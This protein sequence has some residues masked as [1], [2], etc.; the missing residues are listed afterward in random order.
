M[1]AKLTMWGLVFCLV[2]GATLWAPTPAQAQMN[3][4]ELQNIQ[5]FLK[6][7]HSYLEISSQWYSLV[8]NREIAVY[9]AVDGIVELYEQKG[10]KMGAIPVLRD[11]MKRYGDNPTIRTIIRFKI[12]DILKDSGRVDEAL[13]EL[14]AIIDE[15]ARR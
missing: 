1:K 9:L 8:S 7:M 13:K 3:P 5:N 6:L 14:M 10:D 4:Q 11:L 12:R 15:N 2:I